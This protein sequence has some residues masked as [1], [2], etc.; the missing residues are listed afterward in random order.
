MKEEDQGDKEHAP[1]QKRLDDA[2]RRGE[3]PKS[4]ELIT[5]AGYGGLLLA[6]QVAGGVALL[7]AGQIGAVLLGQADRL[8]PMLLTSSRAPTGGLFAAFGAALAPLFLL[9]MAAALLCVVAQQ[10]LIFAPEKLAPTLSRI[11]PLAN[12]K[13]KFGREGLVAFAQSAG[14][15]IVICCLLALF[16]PSQAET[17]LNSLTMTPA[18]ATAAMLQ[19]LMSFLFLTLLIAVVFGGLDFAWQQV[20]HQ[21]RH[22]M[23]RQDLLDEVKDMEGDPHVKARR[24]QRGYDIATNRMLLDVSRADVIIVNPTHFAVAL[25]WQ[26]SD[27]TAPVCLAKGTDEIAARIRQRAALAGV[28]VHSDPPTARALYATVE[29]GAQ[30]RPEHYRA[31]AAGIRFAEAMRKRARRLQP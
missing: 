10:A 21:H 2:R 18:Q 24:R 20:Q 28:P 13:E 11:S 27:R 8:A 6:G 7:Q 31:V 5:A 30:I 1:T 12:A 4:A 23:S 29:I 17:I 19:I 15:L 9:P 26:R 3:V 14:K 16:L 22:R 25:K